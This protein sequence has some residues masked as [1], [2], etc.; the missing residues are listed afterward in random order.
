MQS[1]AFWECLHPRLMSYYWSGVGG[2]PIPFVMPTWVYHP[3]YAV[4]GDFSY[5]YGSIP[6]N[7]IFSGMNIHLPLFWCSPGVQGFDTLP[8]WLIW[9]NWSSWWPIAATKNPGG[10]SW[11]SSGFFPWMLQPM[12]VGVIFGWLNHHC[13][14]MDI[15]PWYSTL[16]SYIKNIPW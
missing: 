16:S 2:F 4:G 15:I 6:I 3:Y 9:K 13:S 7:T 12:L 14:L 10:M 11:I 1:I 5:G 8:Y